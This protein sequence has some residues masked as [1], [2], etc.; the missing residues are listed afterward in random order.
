MI[1]FKDKKEKDRDMANEDHIEKNIMDS[2]IGFQV[3][4]FYLHL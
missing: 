1:K 2:N 4:S 3:L